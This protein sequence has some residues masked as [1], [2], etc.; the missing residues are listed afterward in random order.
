MA[1][2]NNN[3]KAEK[4]H[5]ITTA[6][7]EPVQADTDKQALLKKTVLVDALDGWK[8]GILAIGTF[9][10]DPLKPLIGNPYLVL[11]S[12]EDDADTPD[13]SSDDDNDNENDSDDDSEEDEVNPLMF[14][15]LGNSFKDDDG[16]VIV[17]EECLSIT[18]DKKNLGRTTLADLFLA[19][20]DQADIKKKMMMGKLGIA[21]DDDDFDEIK[22]TKKMNLLKAKRGLSFAKKLIPK[23]KDEASPI[24][25][26]QRVSAYISF[27]LSFR[28]ILLLLSY[29]S[30]T[31]L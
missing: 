27:S 22:Y 3:I 16:C 28:Y 11:H 25:N 10:F 1:D 14:T 20:A 21:I 30:I 8:D 4:S 2:D 29:F 13:F 12:E 9:G 19:D 17:D 6:D 23:V 24:K 31:Y 5:V 18:E 26:I 15:S 7:Q